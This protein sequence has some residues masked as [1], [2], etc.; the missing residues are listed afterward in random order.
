[1]APQACEED[2]W[3]LACAFDTLGH[4]LRS[5]FEAMTG[6]YDLKLFDG[7]TLAVPATVIYLAYVVLNT[8]I[9]LNLLSKPFV[10]CLS[11]AVPGV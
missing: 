2:E 1:L 3:G 11:S 8:I 7:S 4:T 5:L 9:L 6:G 10:P